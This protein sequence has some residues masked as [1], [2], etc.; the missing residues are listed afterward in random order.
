M[1]KLIFYIYS[2]VFDYYPV[3]KRNLDKAKWKVLE[4]ELFGHPKAKQI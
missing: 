2:F 3:Y 1:N 4:P